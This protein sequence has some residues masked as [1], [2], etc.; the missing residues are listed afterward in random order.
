MIEQ[1]DELEASR[2]TAGEVSTVTNFRMLLAQ[3][4]QRPNFARE[5]D[6]SLFQSKDP[7]QSSPESNPAPKPVHRP[8]LKKPAPEKKRP[9]SA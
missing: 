7:L 5:L 8:M 3:Q 2:T 6:A 9:S 4:L 1:V